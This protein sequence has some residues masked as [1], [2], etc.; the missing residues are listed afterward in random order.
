MTK[1]LDKVGYTN[2]LKEVVLV[3]IDRRSKYG[4]SWRYR[5]EYQFM[6]MV[7]EKVDRLEYN[8]FNQDNNYEHKKDC[9]VDLINWSLFYLQMELEGNGYEKLSKPTEKDTGKRNEKK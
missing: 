4:D 7:K 1:L 6:A 3:H 9:L 5:K 2:A 8:F